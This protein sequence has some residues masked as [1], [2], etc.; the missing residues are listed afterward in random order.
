VRTRCFR[1]GR[2]AYLA[3]VA[4]IAACVFLLLLAGCSSSTSPT[5]GKP[6]TSVTTIGL[7][8][9]TTTTSTAVASSSTTTQ[10]ALT[11]TAWYDH[12]AKPAAARIEAALTSL[13]RATAALASGGTG[14]LI[15]QL[16]DCN[17]LGDAALD[18]RIKTDTTFNPPV[19][20]V[21][22]IPPAVGAPDPAVESAWDAFLGKVLSVVGDHCLGA[23]STAALRAANAS[24]SSFRAALTASSA[25]TT[26]T[27]AAPT[28]T[29]AS[30]VAAK[31]KAA[32]LPVNRLIV[33]N[34]STDPNHLLGRPG[35][36]TSK[37]AWVDPDVPASDAD[38]SDVGGI[39]NGG[40]VE[41]F[42]TAAEARARAVYLFTTGQA[43]PALGVEYDYL[44][45]GVLLRLSQYLTPSQ[46]AQWGKVIGGTLYSPS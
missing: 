42:P 26:T 35:E 29:A 23:Q 19:D 31:L 22:G 45:G 38:P 43:D 2:R 14:A 24:Y 5:T 3:A 4:T 39:E 7:A 21:A 15:S 40:G 44:A 37:V 30:R 11:D 20:T 18:A 12:Y 46:A 13:V 33:W 25:T 41:V 27:G 10:P 8:T 28:T 16:D 34:A 6:S 32:G 36:Y 9:T 1:D 17:S